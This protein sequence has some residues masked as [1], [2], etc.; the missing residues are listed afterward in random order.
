MEVHTFSEE[1]KVEDWVLNNSV[2]FTGCKSTMDDIAESDDCECSLELM[3]VCLVGQLQGD[4]EFKGSIYLKTP[5]GAS[6]RQNGTQKSTDL[7]EIEARLSS[8]STVKGRFRLPG[9]FYRR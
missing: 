3:G 2:Y 9:Y 1:Q 5:D 4:L 7:T 6:E 8:K